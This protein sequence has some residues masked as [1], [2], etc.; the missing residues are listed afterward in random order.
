M[1]HNIIEYNP[2]YWIGEF[3]WNRVFSSRTC[4]ARNL[5]SYL[6]LGDHIG[7]DPTHV[8]LPYM[9]IKEIFSDY[10]TVCFSKRGT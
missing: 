9:L 7:V 4:K 10:K 6:R 3:V 5:S 1:K 8:I 2:T